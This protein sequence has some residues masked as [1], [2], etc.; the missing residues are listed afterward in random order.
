M[1]TALL[2]SMLLAAPSPDAVPTSRAEAPAQQ[3][4]YLRLSK[5]VNLR[6]G[7]RVR[8]YFRA[9]ADGYLTVFRSEPDGRVRVLFPLDPFDDNFVRGGQEYELRGR[10]D[11]ESFTVYL[12]SGVGTVYAA[13]S[14]DP[15]RYDSYARGSHWDYGQTDLWEVGSD[16]E[17]DLTYLADAMAGGVSF[18]YDVVRYS[19]SKPRPYSP[20]LWHYTFSGRG[21]YDH[22]YYDP[23]RHGYR[24]FYRPRFSV[25]VNFG[26]RYYP[27]YGDRWDGYA[28]WDPYY[29]DPIYYGDYDYYGHHYYWRPHYAAFHLPVYRHYG[30]HRAPR[31]VYVERARAVNRAYTFKSPGGGR[32]VAD[33]RSRA[34]S[35]QV[36][37][38]TVAPSRSSS[39]GKRVTASR[40]SSASVTDASRASRSGGVVRSIRPAP[41]ARERSATETRRTYPARE[42]AP[43]R[44]T[45]RP[46][47]SPSR[48]RP[49]RSAT[50]SRRAR[51]AP[52]V[53]RDGGSSPRAVPRNRS[54]RPGTP[55][56]AS[57]RPTATRRG[58]E[59]TRGRAGPARGSAARGAGR[60]RVT[61]PSA[62]SPRGRRDGARSARPARP[63]GGRSSPSR[64]SRG[65]RRGR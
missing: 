20:S 28:G 50:P 46:R 53:R 27:S 59:A 3:Q 14:R 23:Y 16:P 10:G 29:W 48:E 43:S 33:L 38:R 44:Q 52:Q 11:R 62:S 24:G 18:D 63:S 45:T 35:N 42:A 4:V 12:S 5:H 54:A 31:V 47:V 60:A 2:T 21:Y 22:H 19:V 37:R 1:L 17:T 15:F 41:Q 64:G 61:R 32:R 58:T 9:S 13:F 65:G 25:H 34:P 39:A 26:S 57:G 7:E 51:P 36:S 30:F 8:A 55:S 6:S 40:R 56:T 49:S